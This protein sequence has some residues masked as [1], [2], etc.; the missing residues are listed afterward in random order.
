MK[1]GATFPINQFLYLLANAVPDATVS[2]PRRVRISSQMRSF[3]DPDAVGSPPRC[4]KKHRPWNTR[5]NAA[6]INCRSKE[7]LTKKTSEECR[8]KSD[9]TLFEDEDSRPF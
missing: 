3:L 2:R 7:T 1:H 4:A 6:N 9:K 8:F 5:N